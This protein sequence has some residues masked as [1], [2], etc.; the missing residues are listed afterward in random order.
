MSVFG[1][2]QKLIKPFT[3]I[4]GCLAFIEYFWHALSS[5]I[6]YLIHLNLE[7]LTVFLW[8]LCDCIFW[9]V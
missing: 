5:N 7:N 1:I 3:F 6:V 2:F 8:V 9:H 4:S